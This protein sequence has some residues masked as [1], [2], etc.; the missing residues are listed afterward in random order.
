M[1]KTILTF[2]LFMILAPI[3][4]HAQIVEYHPEA[5][6][7]HSETSGQPYYK[8]NVTS[9]GTT[10]SLSI[11]VF[12]SENDVDLSPFTSPQI[13]GEFENFSILI[14]NNDGNLN[15]EVQ[16]SIGSPETGYSKI[17]SDSFYVIDIQESQFVHLKFMILEDTEEIES[18]NVVVEHQIGLS[19]EE[20]DIPAKFSLSQ[21][22]PNPFNPSTSIRFDLRESATISLVIYDLLG[23]EVARLVDSER[24]PAGT[25]Q[26]VWE[27]ALD[28]GSG[29]YVYQIRTDGQ[30]KTR[31]MTLIK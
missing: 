4:L 1:K 11:Q 16:Y 3:H 22:Y 5:D 14:E 30:I 20:N 7:L 8:W 6:S 25:H 23:R 24:L 2:F 28:V 17:P 12:H 13:E 18:L 27:P 15:Y 31:K 9:N 19:V 29:I 21:N 10:D 26:R